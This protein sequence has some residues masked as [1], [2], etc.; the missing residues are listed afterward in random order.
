MKKQFSNHTVF[1]GVDVSKDSL[2]FYCP[3]TEKLLKIDNSEEA[4]TEFLQKLQ[5]RKRSVM[6]V[7]EATGGYET[8][9]VNQLAMHDLKAAGINPRR[10][11][12]FAKGIGIDAKTD[13]IDAKE[14][15]KYGEV[16]SPKSMAMKSE[17]ELKHG[18]LAA[19]RNQLLE[20][21]GQENNRLGQCWDDDAKESIR[22]VLKT[23]KKQLKCIDSQLAKMLKMDKGNQRTIKILQAVKGVGPVLTS[24]AHR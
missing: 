24:G 20:L 1:V 23:L 7:M 8:L 16:V 3:E 14:I 9:L 6:V 22:E 15:S 17:H 4:V 11:R 2:D 18:A 19:R 5:K 10:V 12:D 13:S 21:I